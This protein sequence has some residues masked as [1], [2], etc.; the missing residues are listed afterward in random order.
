[1]NIGLTGGIATGKSTVSSMLVE[2][3][4]ALI[5]ADQVAREV[6][7]PGSPYLADIAH[8]FGQAV[9]NDDGSLNRGKLAKII[10]NDD[11]ARKS[12]EAILHPPIRETMLSRMQQLEAERSDRLVVVD[13]P[14]LFES[15]LQQYFSQVMLVYVPEAIQ[16]QRL[17][18]RDGLDE[19]EARARISAQMAIEE[20]RKL[21]DVIIDNSGSLQAT[22]AQIEQFMKGL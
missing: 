6:V 1:M 22:E 16:L 17:M 4:A 12:L 14:L 13:I 19:A 20:K 9:I 3:G 18:K 10:F 21:A 2:R 8:Q 7:M 15:G 5:D 11:E